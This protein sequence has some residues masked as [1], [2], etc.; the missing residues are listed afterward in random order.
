MGHSQTIDSSLRA[1]A[2]LKAVGKFGKIPGR[3]A[4]QKILYFVNLEEKIFPYQWNSYG[5]YSE[6]VKY[7]LED[8]VSNHQISVEREELHTKGRIQFNMKI[9]EDGGK[10]LD[11]MGQSPEVDSRVE[12]VHELLAGRSPRMMELLA[13]VHY[14]ASYDGGRCFDR[15]FD[16]ISELKPDANFKQ[17]DVND[18]L[19]ELQNADLLDVPS[20]KIAV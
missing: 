7:M 6:E 19:S 18:A 10:H 13:S 4:L 20:S 2:I 11:L 9:T 8:M 5:P 15:T 1:Y 12:S 14:I 3:K 17:D 16:I